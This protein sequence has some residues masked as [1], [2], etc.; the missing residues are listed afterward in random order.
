MRPN[1]LTTFLRGTIAAR[2]PVLLTGS[3]GIGK[4]SIV[5]AAA[6]QAGNRI[7]VSHPA[8]ADPTDAK[9]FPW[10]EP[11][12]GVAT[13][14]PF[15]DVAEL[16]NATEPTVWFLDDL[17][18]APPSVQAAY[19]PWLLARQ[20]NGHKLPD[21]VTI[22]A[23]TNR[24][25]DRAGVTGVLEPVKSRF[26]A[27]VELEADLDEWT[28][29]ALGVD[30]VPPELVAFLRFQPD[31]F[32]NFVPSADLVNCPS[33]R[34][35]HNAGKLL[36]L[37]LPAALETAALTGAVGAGAAAACMAF[38]S[39]YRA[40]P[41]IDAILMD[42]DNAPLPEKVDVRYAV[43]TALA[44]RANEQNFQRIARYCE[45]LVNDG[46]A[47]FAVLCIRDAVRRDKMVTATPAFIKLMSG[48]LGALV[49]GQA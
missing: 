40:L 5:T 14:L 28:Q 36:R 15:G 7:V 21:C 8:V 22:I 41:S 10:A 43:S 19:M 4:T 49:G 16:L 13:F 27:I 26:A 1:D 24:R 37:Q 17:G 35:W 6:A 18:Q 47:E 39:M 45:R 12:A 44:S 29:W 42:P 23:A 34:T 20:V 25:T 33:P 11:G 48:D 3:P 30:A 32:N 31:L 2:L 38:M 9:G 46:Q